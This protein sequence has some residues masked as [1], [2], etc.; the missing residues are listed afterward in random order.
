MLAVG[1]WP[2]ELR[3]EVLALHDALDELAR[4]HPQQAKAVECHFFAGLKNEEAAAVMGIP[5]GTYRRK[6]ALGLA[7]LRTKSGLLGGV[8]DD[9]S[10]AD[11][12]TP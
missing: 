12:E 9:A 6:L 7:W 10:G 1:R 3:A 8:P 4:I 2:E 5:F 11:H